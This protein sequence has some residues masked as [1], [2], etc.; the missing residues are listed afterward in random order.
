V[1]ALIAAAEGAT[2]ARLE[3]V[4]RRCGHHVVSVTSLS[5]LVSTLAGDPV[6]VVVLA[7]PGAVAACRAIRGLAGPTL[8]IL[9]VLGPDDA[10]DPIAV[11][12]AG[13]TELV[14]VED[15][16]TTRLALVERRLARAAAVASSSG[17]ATLGDADFR[18]VLERMSDLVVLHRMGTIVYVNPAVLRVL[19]LPSL[20][21]VIG[22]HVA[23]FVHPD[24]R[25]L[26]FDRIALL[27]Q[28]ERALP[29][30]EQRF[31]AT[32]GRVVVLETSPVPGVWFDGA[33]TALVVA[34]D[35][36]ERR[37]METQLLS[38]ERM[39]S[40]GSLAACIAHQLNNPLTYVLGNLSYAAR[41]LGQLLPGRTAD[42]V[43]R[44][45][46]LE[47]ALADARQGVERVRNV[48]AELTTLSRP[49]VDEDSAL[50]VRRI[51]ESS[52]TLASNEIRHRAR[53]EKH[54]GELPAVW[55]NEVSLGL[56]FLNLLL[57]A[58]RRIEEGSASAHA[59][60]VRAC[61]DASGWAEI[62]IR[63]RAPATPEPTELDGSA[64]PG[65]HICHT[66]V[67]AIGGKLVTLEESGRAVGHVV[68]LPPSAEAPVRELREVRASLEP[69][70]IGDRRAR[71]L[72]V[73]DE[74][75]IA[76]TMRRALEGHDL[77]VVTSGRD[78]LELCRGMPFDLVLCDLMMPDLTGMKDYPLGKLTVHALR[79]VD[80]TIDAGEF[81]SIAG[82]SGSGKTT[83]L[84]LIGCVDVP[85][86]GTVSVDGQATSSLDDNGLTKLRLHKLGF[87]FQ[88]FN[89][90]GV[91]DVFQNVEFP[92]LLQGGMDK[93][94]RRARVEAIVEGVGLTPQLRQRPNELSG[95]Q[96]QR[97]AIARALVTGP[98]I[99][100]ADEPTANLDSKTGAAII[101]LMKELN[102]RD[103][104][105][106]I[107][108]THDAEVMRHANRVIRLAD[109]VIIDDGRGAATDAHPASPA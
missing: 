29:L 11:V 47:I 106:F 49:E 83:L 59:L 105:T 90:I 15:E 80:L 33:P 35:I 70:R 86:K 99:V 84:N 60:S 81:V 9:A 76:A 98:R 68:R 46:S 18:I 85:T 108:S 103:G 67:E 65:L 55:A 64:P 14:L 19:E 17:R 73:D 87:I 56:V 78:A 24:D 5:T 95:G 26:L 89:L 38:A 79:G 63:E 71:I 88:T 43:A 25:A 74:P 93:A 57:V 94:A 66:I 54:I 42:E 23:E 22:R 28:S 40:V 32:S 91:L 41:G 82:P 10:R 109:G 100:L 62:V 27:S 48:V 13:A 21:A 102:R 45:V 1:R 52:I 101:D 6:D 107:F 36:T 97:V 4:V 34:R 2:S 96:R 20:E 104:T 72:V 8:P 30:A 7:L 31:F 53:L 12:D 3:G 92:L 75:V 39:A 16:L 44:V 58:A 51:L 37:Q 77:Y 69:A 61:T 50:E